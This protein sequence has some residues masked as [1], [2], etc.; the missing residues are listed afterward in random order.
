VH[1][2]TG[3]HPLQHHVVATLLVV[4]LLVG[5]AFSEAQQPAKTCSAGDGTLFYIAYLY[6]W[7]SQPS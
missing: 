2:T 6:Y 4:L 5:S 1:L 7:S 3:S